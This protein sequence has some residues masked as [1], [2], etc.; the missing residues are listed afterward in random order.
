VLIA[1]K[2]FKETSATEIIFDMKQS[3]G[4]GVAKRDRNVVPSSSFVTAY[5]NEEGQLQT[6]FP[7]LKAPAKK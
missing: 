1:Y 4:R 2:Q 5:F 3:I 6:I 7:L